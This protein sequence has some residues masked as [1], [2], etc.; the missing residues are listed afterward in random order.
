MWSGLVCITVHAPACYEARQSITLHLNL[1]VIVSP[2][3]FLA[4]SSRSL[5]LIPRS[6]LSIRNPSVWKYLDVSWGIGQVLRQVLCP[7]VENNSVTSD[8]RRILQHCVIDSRLSLIY[9][10]PCDLARSRYPLSENFRRTST[11]DSGG[12]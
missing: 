7:G 9:L 5:F 2:R 6:H 4:L 1:P 10:D 12:G 11:R 3:F 8:T